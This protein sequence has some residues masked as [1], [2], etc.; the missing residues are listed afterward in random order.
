VV[1]PAIKSVTAVPAGS[2]MKLS[3]EKPVCQPKDNP[4]GGFRIYRKNDCTTLIPVPC[5]TGAPSAAGFSLVGQTASGVFSFTDNNGG[6]GLVVGQNYSY[7]V[8]AYYFDGTESF[9]STAVCAELKRDVPVI[10]NVDIEA[11]AKDTGIVHVR[12]T[13]PL[14][15][16]GNLDTVAFP[17]PYQFLLKHR[18]GNGGYA[19]I[20]TSSKPF[21]YQLDT[22][23]AHENVNTVDS[24]HEYI[25]EFIS[26]TVS[27][28]SSRRATS[29]YLEL[30]PNDRRMQLDWSFHTP[31]DNKRYTIY[32][33]DP[34]SQSFVQIGVTTSTSY[35]DTMNVVNRHV[36]CYRVLSEG[37]YSDPGIF[38]PLLNRS[39]IAC[40]T[41]VDLTPPCTPSLSIQADCPKGFVGLTWNN[42]R[43]RRCGDD[44]IRYRLFRKTEVNGQYTKVAEGFYTSFVY[45]GL[46]EILGCYAV[47]AIDSS[48]NESPMSPDFCIDNCPEFE[49]PNLFSPNGDNA[50]DHYKAIKVRQIKEIDLNVV[51]RWGNLIYS[52]SDPYFMWDGKSQMTK[53]D[54]NEGTYF[55]VCHVFEPRL[56][57]IVR[58][59]IRGYLQ[60]VR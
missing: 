23:Y 32:R 51:D 35:L 46:E 7:L 58:R 10:L 22:F 49:L 27:I 26:G 42:V 50:N 48:G 1:P 3:W 29:V 57:G 53:Q 45:D 18:T 37:E 31:W 28:G 33:Q 16:G 4:L 20:F 24:P 15:T 34:G 5:Q 52:T 55:Y 17:G 30:T 19:V 54:V 21:V 13:R 56:S 39:Q 38:K 41:V 59:T 43:E 12:W 44:V 11:T 9:A 25:I 8:V 14:T 36:Y 47:V 60:V 6:D 2:E 40:D